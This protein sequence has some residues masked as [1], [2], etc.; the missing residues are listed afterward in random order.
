MREALDD[1]AEGDGDAWL[2]CSHAVAG[3][4][5]SVHRMGEELFRTAGR[6]CLAGN[7]MHTEALQA[8]AGSGA[9]GWCMSMLRFVG[10]PGGGAAGRT[11]QAGARRRGRRPHTS[12]PSTRYWS[13][14]GGRGPGTQLGGLP[15]R[16]TMLCE[17]HSPKLYTPPHGLL[18]EIQTSLQRLSDQ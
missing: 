6:C 1:D 5:P 11:L 17:H 15:V 13:P 12:S 10:Y 14:P 2:R 3:R 8:D 18:E 16:H 7:A 9:F 4:H